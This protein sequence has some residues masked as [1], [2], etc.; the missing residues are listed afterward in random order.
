MRGSHVVWGRVQPPIPMAT[1]TEQRE[2]ISRCRLTRTEGRKTWWDVALDGRH[3]GMVRTRYGGMEYW[4]AD[5]DE[6]LLAPGQWNEEDPPHCLAILALIDYATT[7][8][9]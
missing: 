3:L 5:R 6:L 9:S 7:T 2:L 4:P 1:N 8:N